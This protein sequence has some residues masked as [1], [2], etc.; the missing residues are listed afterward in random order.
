MVLENKKNKGLGIK[1][2]LKIVGIVLYIAI[3]IYLFY[4]LINFGFN[5]IIIS[6]LLVFIILTTIGPFLR[7]NKRRTIY[8]R[9]F[10]EGR[11]GT[12]LNTQSR[13]ERINDGEKLQETVQKIPKPINLEY[14]YHKPIIS[15]CKYCGNIVPNFVKKC[16]FCNKHI[17]L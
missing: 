1:V 7:R 13:T 4:L 2:L 6:I 12:K 8:S 15:K 16:P 9:M 14:E 11:S 10:S 5:P 3:F 17:K